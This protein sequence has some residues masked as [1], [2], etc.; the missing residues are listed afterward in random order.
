MELI[1]IQ[2]DKE[3]ARSLLKLAD[4]RYSKISQFDTAK[5]TPLITE[6]YYEICKELITAILFLDGYKTLSHKDLVKYMENELSE[7]NIQI[8]DALRK[9][10]NKIVY[11]GIMV[12]ANYIE[13]NQQNFEEIVNQLRQIIEKRIS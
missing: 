3:R 9:R 8:L 10:R 11:Y 6:S 13:R 5:E 2:P 1:K 12:D 4:L 7:K